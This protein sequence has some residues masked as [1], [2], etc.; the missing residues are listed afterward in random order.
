MGLRAQ[1]GTRAVP[2]HSW[3]QPVTC[4]GPRRDPFLVTA[5]SPLLRAL[6]RGRFGSY[7]PWAA[8]FAMDTPD[9]RMS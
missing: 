5:Q 2:P 6:A 9:L 4:T 1:Q 8:E 7:S 3:N